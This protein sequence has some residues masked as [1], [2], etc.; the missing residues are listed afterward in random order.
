MEETCELIKGDQ[1]I[2]VMKQNETSSAYIPMRVREIIQETLSSS[3]WEKPLLATSFSRE[4]NLLKELDKSQHLLSQSRKE[5]HD[6]GER[7]VP[8]SKKARQSHP[9]ACMRIH[10]Q[11][12]LGKVLSGRAD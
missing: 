9:L 11:G 12:F 3:G 8:V 10:T 4:S 1:P 2:N 7:F 6:L 5:A